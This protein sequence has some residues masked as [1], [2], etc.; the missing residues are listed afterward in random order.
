MNG[1]WDD[2][3]W[4]RLEQARG[5]HAAAGRWARFR[6]ATLRMAQLRARQGRLEDALITYLELCYID[7][8][9]AQNPGAAWGLPIHE[10]DP[11]RGFGLGPL[12]VRRVRA[13]ARDLGY[14]ARRVEAEFLATASVM[15]RRLELPVGPEEAWSE[16]RRELAFGS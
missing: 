16:L 10:L 13:L 11:L 14:D 7:L 5:E 1:M 12:I 8:N 4:E 6:T 3:E 9:G 15:H 2:S